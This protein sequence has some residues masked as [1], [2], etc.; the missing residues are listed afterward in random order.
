[1]GFFFLNINMYE[2]IFSVRYIDFFCGDDWCI[3][4]VGYG[5]VVVFVVFGIDEMNIIIGK[6]NVIFV[7]CY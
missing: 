3:V 1:M 7:V 4:V 5:I 2:L 6:G